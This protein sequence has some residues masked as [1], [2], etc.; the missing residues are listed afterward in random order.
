MN[1]V[2]LKV[3]GAQGQGVNSVGEMCAKGLKRRGYC[4]FGYREYM[5]LI[6][7]GHSSY[8]LDVSTKRVQST[9][10]T[11][12]ILVNFNHH[13]LEKNIDDVKE[14][15]IILHM[16]PEWTFPEEHQK[17]IDQR[18][19]R[20][21]Y[22]PTE[23][24]LKEL[25]A[26][27]ILGNVLITSVVWS[28]L[29]CDPENLKE[30]AREQFGHKGEEVLNKN[31]ACID[32]GF[33]F[34]QKEAADMHV[35]LPKAD[36]GWKDQMLLTGNQAMGIGVI[37]AG[38]R[39]FVGYP[40]TPSSPL[41]TYIAAKQ[42]ETGMVIKQ[43]E[44]EITAVQMMSG[45]ML[46][47][48]R[49]MTATSGGGYDLMTETVSMNGIMENP[50]VIAMVQR[51]GP[52]TALPTWTA[53]GDLLMTVGSSHG[54]FTKLVMSAS[55]SQD[56][57]DLMPEAFNYAEEF[58][59]PV[60][61][62]SDKQTAEA[63]WTQAAFDQKST[64]LKRGKLVTDTKQLKKLKAADRYDP[65]VSDGVTQRWL[66]GAEAQVF[67]TQADEHN[68]EGS[69]D[70]SGE[71]AAEQVAKRMRKMDALRDALPDP[72]LYEDE[73]PEILI[74]SWGSN[75]GVILD[76]LEDEALK[77]KKIGYLHYTYL[78][79][80]RTKRFCDLAGRAKKVILVEGNHQ[81]QLGM[82]LKMESGIGIEEKILKFDGRPFFVDELVSLIKEKVS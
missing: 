74:V 24:I 40:M 34:K 33:A 18:K 19:V 76:A 64:E 72:H 45:A 58:Q 39:M 6:K 67:C 42:N 28:L 63:L 11:V 49:S 13:G 44:D 69:P 50:A 52:G 81:G 56:S 55:D 7:G 27:S 1:R 30:L 75:K 16:T 65:S 60:I 36:G 77:D 32:A 15:G 22:L 4:V 59:T 54:E 21:I 43:A 26:P 48:T 82:L 25:K 5:S 2:S 20:V 71:N 73:D 10:T 79:P 14:G 31:F 35:D 12:N 29:G 37:H 78:W 47:G 8:Q 70:E 66:P 61:V 68:A 41:L 17:I 62:M 53:Q 80:L 23:E 57:F 46:M 51:P 9:E 38:C 3:T